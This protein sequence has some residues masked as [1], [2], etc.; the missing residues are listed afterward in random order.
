MQRN[1]T[2]TKNNNLLA[3]LQKISEKSQKMR[4]H[5]LKVMKMNI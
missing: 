4:N 3:G 1:T 5:F 2:D